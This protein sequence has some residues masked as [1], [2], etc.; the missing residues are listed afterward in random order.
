MNCLTSEYLRLGEKSAAEG[1]FFFVSFRLSTSLNG[2]LSTN[3]FVQVSISTLII[4]ACTYQMSQVC[5]ICSPN[6]FPNVLSTVFLF[7]AKFLT[8]IQL[9]FIFEYTFGMVIQ[10]F[11]PNFAGSHVMETSALLPTSAFHSDWYQ[12]KYANKTAILIFM[13]K[14]LRPFFLEAGV[15]F[16]LNLRMFILVSQTE[17]FTIDIDFE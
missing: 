1:K 9:I 12:W 11:T 6:K 4:C 15:F 3:Y 8:L 17:R 7:K 14:T 13:V 2:I 5:V 16:Q 10:I